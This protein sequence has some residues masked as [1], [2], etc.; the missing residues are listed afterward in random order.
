MSDYDLSQAEMMLI[1]SHSEELNEAL[2][3][4]KTPMMSI[5][6]LNKRELES[7]KKAGFPF[8]CDTVAD[9]KLELKKFL[10]EHLCC[11]SDDMYT[12]KMKLKYYVET[13]LSPPVDRTRKAQKKAH[14]PRTV[15]KRLIVE[16]DEEEDSS[17]EE[18][19]TE[20]PPKP[21][22]SSASTKSSS[23][24]AKVYKVEKKLALSDSVSS[25]ESSE[26]PKP[27]P[28]PKKSKASKDESSSDVDNQSE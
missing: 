14:K 4:L 1:D 12:L 7:I 17:E 28:K 20:P 25:D 11:G 24:K 8:C 19:H 9:R 15:P 3:H 13:K 18:S 26:E 10:Q 27:K 16:Y 6:T 2:V 22:R 21:K 23:K 5:N